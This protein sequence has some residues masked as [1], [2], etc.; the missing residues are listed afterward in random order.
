MVV[1]QSSRCAESPTPTRNPTDHTVECMSQPLRELRA[2]VMQQRC[3]VQQSLAAAA[4]SQNLQ[5][6]SKRASSTAGPKVLSR[7]QEDRT[8]AVVAPMHARSPAL[9]AM[10][11]HGASR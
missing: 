11:L 9:A 1:K 10:L 7:D 8:S 2:L 4:L 6:W 3:P 5:L